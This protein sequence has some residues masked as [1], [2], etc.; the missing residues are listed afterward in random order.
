MGLV[1]RVPRRLR[2]SRRFTFDDDVEMVVIGR[3]PR[4]SDI[5]FPPSLQ[6]VGLEH[7]A[8]KRVLGR[9]RLVLNADDPVFV[10]GR[11]AYDGQELPDRCVVRL[12]ARGP[13]L[14]V[15]TTTRTDLPPVEREMEA[16]GRSASPRRLLRSVRR[17]RN[18]A[19]AATALVVLATALLI[20]STWRSSRPKEPTGEVALGL[21]LERAAPSVYR[22]VVRTADGGEYS[23]AT[24]WVVAPGRLATNAHVA[25]Q[26]EELPAGGVLQV[27]SSDA[28][29]RTFDVLS[30]TVHPGFDAFEALWGGYQPAEGARAGRLHR[31]R[32]AGSG[33]D[34]AI[35]EVDPAAALGPPLALAD[36]PTLLVLAPGDPVGYVG[37]PSES[38]ALSGSPVKRP[39]AH[40]Q[41]GRITLMTNFFGASGTAKSKHLI[42]HTCP[43]TGGS[44]GSPLIDARGRVIGL[45]SAGNFAP[46]MMG[47][48]PSGVGINFAQR[49]DLLRELLEGQAEAAQADRTNEWITSIEDL[50]PSAWRIGRRKMVERRLSSLSRAHQQ[51]TRDAEYIAWTLVTT[52]VVDGGV[53]PVP[54]PDRPTL[55]V[56]QGGRHLL[57]ASPR[58]QA[59]A[60]ISATFEPTEGPP[61]EL[62]ERN[63]AIDF[64]AS[65]PGVLRVAVVVGER[66]V[67]VELLLHHGQ[68]RPLTTAVVRDQVL[69]DW[70][71][72]LEQRSYLGLSADPRV[73]L[74]AEATLD[75]ADPWEPVLTCPEMGL[76][77]VLVVAR[78]NEGV[79]LH[80]QGLGG[81][82]GSPLPTLTR[83]HDRFHVRQGWGAEDLEVTLRVERERGVTAE[84]TVDL[85]VWVAAS[86]R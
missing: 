76:Y 81:P 3:D 57:L 4:R 40:R 82:L 52:L 44:S 31:I 33:A 30:V 15:E 70:V 50:Y 1:I 54:D 24:A 66:P 45:I 80:V 32:S 19:L 63:R 51:S 10:N 13:R 27:R 78:E 59:E 65:G 49:V 68:P 47:R 21:A 58:L 25:K 71:N 64:E 17:N 29:P 83:G 55:E 62:T 56:L 86:M 2:K 67:P 75:D 41:M 22:V 6:V 34:V 42:Q 38:L 36:E 60:S 61:V 23:G 8:M 69:G 37:Y 12:G 74:E 14:V 18:L 35:L 85:I 9:Y 20:W 28:L 11:E 72:E 5:M 48:I 79:S 77:L 16:H 73:V 39:L 53:E 7:M 26:F 46:G 43:G 84:V